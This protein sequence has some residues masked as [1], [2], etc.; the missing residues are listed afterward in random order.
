VNGRSLR[1][2]RNGVRVYYSAAIEQY[3]PIPY[4]VD[5]SSA[6]SQYLRFLQLLKICDFDKAFSLNDFGCGYGALL[7]YLRLHHRGARVAYRGID[8]SP[9]M[10]AAATKRWGGR[11]QTTFAVGSRCIKSA[12]YSIASG[13]FN[14]RLGQPVASWEAYIE[15]TLRDL[16]AHSRTGFAVNFMLPRP[17]API[18]PELYRSPMRPWVMFCR[19]ELGG[20]VTPVTR[21][22][23]R[24]FTLLVR[25]RRG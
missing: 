22:G 25:T 21:Y 6:A 16:C 23:L 18:E 7:Q 3:G 10:I 13:V 15:H 5:W 9:A 14:V 2:I 1:G 24:E 11:S 17:G 8:L 19:E 12:D 4:G 20:S